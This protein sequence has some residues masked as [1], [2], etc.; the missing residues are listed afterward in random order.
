MTSTRLSP[1]ARIAELMSA[2]REVL[3]EVGFDRFLPAEVARRCGVSEALVYR[4]FPTK[5]DLL[6]RVVEE[7]FAE[8]LAVE[9]EVDKHEGTYE[10]LRYL[11]ASGLAVVRAEPT[12]TRYLFL[13]LRQAAD[14]KGSSAYQLN[15]RFTSIVERVLRDAIAAGEFRADIDVHLLR[16]MIFGAIEH[17]T[18]AFMRG[19]GDFELQG[20]ADQI[21]A[22]VHRGMSTDPAP[23]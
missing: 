20:T 4:Y 3:R 9:P 23:H 8:I 12:L 21:T 10:R 1:E 13:E 7:W 18:W 22:V 17:R 14:Y 6:T 16:D 19:E 11:I 15:K 2:A 5:R